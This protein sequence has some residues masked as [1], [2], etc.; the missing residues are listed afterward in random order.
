MTSF[1]VN[2]FLKIC[3]YHFFIIVCMLGDTE[4]RQWF[5]AWGCWRHWIL[6]ELK[7][8]MI[9]PSNKAAW[10]QTVFCQSS[11]T[12]HSWTLSNLKKI[13][14]IIK[15]NFW[16]DNCW[17]ISQTIPR[18][19]FWDRDWG[20][21]YIG[22]IPL[23][24]RALNWKD[25]CLKTVIKTFNSSAQ[26]AKAGGSLWASSQSILHCEFKVRQSYIVPPKKGEG[27]IV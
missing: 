22:L 3:L 20:V 10:S 23:L 16:S 5:G 25:L 7:L 1:F 12:S 19:L 17:A 27:S 21:A 6:L 11:I 13:P 15:T 14:I 24:W 4:G 18:L 9:E 26:E 2:C 8:E